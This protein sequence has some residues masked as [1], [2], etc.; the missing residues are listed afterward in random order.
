MNAIENARLESLVDC[1]ATKAI[2]DLCGEDYGTFEFEESF[3]L[4]NGDTCW[5]VGTVN[6]SCLHNDTGARAVVFIDELIGCTE[7]DDNYVVALDD[8]YKK[9]EVVWD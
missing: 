1:I 3:K 8:R 4:A 2:G 7:Y 6:V 9:N 5:A